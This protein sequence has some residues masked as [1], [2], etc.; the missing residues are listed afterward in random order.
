MQRPRRIVALIVTALLA[1]GCSGGGEEVES[2]GGGGDTDKS[3]AVGIDTGKPNSTAAPPATESPQ[4][5]KAKAATL[6]HADFPPGFEPQPEEPGQGL[7]IETLW[8][9][10]SRCLAVDST[11]GRTGM[12]TSPTFLRGLATQARS[13]VEYTSE[14]TA[15]AIFTALA[16]PKS[17]TCLNEA[18][19]A[20]V[21]RSAPEGAVPGQVAV[22]ALAA[23]PAA[24]RI[25]SFRVT[26]TLDLDGLKVPLFQDFLV[27]F[28]R[29]AVVRFFYLNPGAEFPQDLE[30]S[31]VQKVLSRV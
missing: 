28:E 2:G 22:A 7:Q 31:T 17:Q 18:F 30:R 23:P 15:N 20:D 25:S 5:V 21:K 11:A 3:G 9:E 10:L 6:Q 12:A 4:T 27:A 13:T 16:G 26:V 19:G 29:G 8:A 14:A 1:A 24:Q